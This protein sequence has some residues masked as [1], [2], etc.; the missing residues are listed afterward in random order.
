MFSPTKPEDC[1]DPEGKSVL[2]DGE[3]IRFANMLTNDVTATDKANIWQEVL[4]LNGRGALQNGSNYLPITFPT[5]DPA[6][7]ETGEALIQLVQAKPHLI[8]VVDVPFALPMME[9]IEEQWLPGTRRPI[10]LVT[11]LQIEEGIA[12]VVAPNEDFRRRIIGLSG[13]RSDKD[14][15]LIRFAEAY[16][17][18]FAARG[19]TTNGAAMATVDAVFM[20]SYAVASLGA[21]PVTGY[22]VGLAMWDVTNRAEGVPIEAG[23]ENLEAGFAALAEGKKLAY[24]GYYSAPEFDENGDVLHTEVLA[25]CVGK[26][27]TTSPSTSGSRLGPYPELGFFYNQDA[28][29][30]FQGTYVPCW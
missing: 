30:Y 15:R 18:R 4:V 6:N 16:G 11:G 1:A 12:D 22:D 29:D 24:R 21:K 23:V 13:D 5:T 8:H 14:P 20:V 27:G 28:P 3:E 9:A 17:E 10:Y 25:W 26:P 7:I 2:E 19:H